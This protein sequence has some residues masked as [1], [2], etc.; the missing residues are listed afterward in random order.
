MA[1]PYM[2]KGERSGS[3]TAHS[4]AIPP[5][6]ETVT[7]GLPLRRGVSRRISGGQVSNSILA[8]NYA[9]YSPD[10][11]FTSLGHN[12]IGN[13]RDAI[14]FVAS[15]LLDVNPQLGPLQNNGGPT[16]TM[17]L[18]P[19]SLAVNAGDN[20]NAP[21][22]DQR[23]AGFPRIVGGTIDIGAFESDNGPDYTGLRI[24]N[25]TATEG[26][27]GTVNA[28]V[29][30]TLSA[31]VTT[32]VTV[33]FATSDGSATV[34][35]G[36]YDATSGT[37]TFSPGQTSKT[38]LIPVKGDRT[39]EADEQFYVNLSGATNAYLFDPQG[40]VTIVDDE[41]RVSI[42]N[43]SVTEGNSGT[44]P[45]SF[46]VTLSA[47]YDVATSVNYATAD[48]SATSA[49]DYTADSGTLTIPAGQTSGTIT[50][51]VNGDRLPEANEAFF[52]N[53]SGATNAIIADA[54]G[55]GAIVDNEPRIS[56]SDVSKAEGKNR[57]TTLFTFTVTL[58]APY[59]Q[60]VTMS[61]RT[62][63]GTATTGDSDY[64]AKTGTLT[65][66]PGETTKTITI[67]VKGDNNEGSRMRHSTWTCSATAAIHCLPR[68]VVSAR[69]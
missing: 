46:T 5:Q 9:D 45:M 19:G 43:A 27:T 12:L 6:V 14:G 62:V 54:T 42:G 24:N 7:Y 44:T 55:V 40:V 15:D 22:Y 49:N 30:V 20:T 2:S 10:G 34:A 33:N 69:S 56:I 25:V 57:K 18:L 17:A 36:D 63:N 29:T 28:A 53:L 35:G 37:L 26:N 11:G 13:S 60:A 39:V 64:I 38:I 51:L 48:G 1:A 47:A 58:S 3:T 8:G 23:G 52:V 50:V 59:D 31:P 16:Q 67:E 21:A 65:F 32:T 4:S 61:Y 68:I 66:N 41:P